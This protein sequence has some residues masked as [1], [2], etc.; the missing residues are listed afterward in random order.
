MSG[1]RIKAATIVSILLL[2]IGLG[3]QSFGHICHSGDSPGDAPSSPHAD[4]RE[5][6]ENGAPG[7]CPA[8]ILMLQ[9]RSSGPPPPVPVEP[10]VA[11]EP[12]HVAC[13]IVPSIPHAG[14]TVARA[15][16]R[17]A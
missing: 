1:D 16:P 13:S 5:G 14:N 10:P 3:V 6:L 15:P 2:L 11:D 17:P 8:C 9:G 7:G 4:C 12:V